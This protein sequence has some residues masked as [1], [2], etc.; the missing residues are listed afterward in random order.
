MPWPGLLCLSGHERVFGVTPASGIAGPHGSAL[1]LCGTRPLRAQQPH[2]VCILPGD[3]PIFPHP[4]Q[5]LLLSG[6]V[7]I[8]ARLA[9]VK[10]CLAVLTGTGLMPRDVGH[11]FLRSLVIR[12]S[13]LENSYST[14]CS[15]YCFKFCVVELIFSVVL[16]SGLRQ[17][18]S[19]PHTSLP[20]P[21]QVMSQLASNSLALQ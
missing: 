19:V 7:K 11:L 20:P 21:L 12:A 13:S 3:V 14:F 16:A 18:E 17:S 5:H 10:Q 4:R 9:G 8:T 1:P 15:F 6:V 2:C